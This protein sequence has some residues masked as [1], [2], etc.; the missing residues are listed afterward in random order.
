MVSIYAYLD[1]SPVTGAR[2]AAGSHPSAL[3]SAEVAL[4]AV[5]FL[6]ELLVSGHSP[7]RLTHLQAWEKARRSEATAT[8]EPTFPLL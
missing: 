1:L 4:L 5:A 7:Q 3:L 2:H 8:N 6:L